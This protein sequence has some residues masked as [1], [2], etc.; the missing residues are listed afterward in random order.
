MKT[1]HKTK[2]D[3]THLTL[4]I[5]SR[6]AISLCGVFPFPKMGADF[7]L[8]YIMYVEPKKNF[9]SRFVLFHINIINFFLVDN[10]EIRLICKMILFDKN[11]F[12]NSHEK[13]IQNEKKVMKT[14][15]DICVFLV[16]LVLQFSRLFSVP[17]N[18]FVFDGTPKKRKNFFSVLF[19]C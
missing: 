18:K 9:C 2:S 13:G 10:R 3:A 16:F 12:H 5:I 4:N 1:I 11:N 7:S 19:V 17:N 6:F 14:F 15:A 8:F